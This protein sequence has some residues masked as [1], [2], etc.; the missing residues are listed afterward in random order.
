MSSKIISGLIALSESGRSSV[1]VPISPSISIESV[2]ELRAAGL[3]VAMLIGGLLESA[4]WRL[5]SEP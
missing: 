2:F 3:I 1:S 5:A 4:K